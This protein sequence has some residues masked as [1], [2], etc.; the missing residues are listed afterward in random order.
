MHPSRRSET[1]HHEAAHA[2]VASRLGFEVGDCTIR[3]DGV[4]EGR[5]ES[6]GEWIDGSRDHD[7]A[8]VYLAGLAGGR[9]IRPESTVEDGGAGSDYEKAERLIGV[10]ALPAAEIEAASLV[11]LHRE[12]I[13]DL[14]AALLQHE[15]LTEDRVSIVI[16]ARADGFEWGELLRIYDERWHRQQ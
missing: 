9:M 12:A 14:A 10:A 1:A 6:E 16:D 5:S 13:L 2:V 4:I 8:L 15:T 3:S 7:Q 11:E